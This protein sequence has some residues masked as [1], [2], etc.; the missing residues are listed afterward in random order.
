MSSSSRYWWVTVPLS[1]GLKFLAFGPLLSTHCQFTAPTLA[2]KVKS[3]VMTDGWPANLSWVSNPIKSPGSY[4]CYCHTIAGLLIWGTLCE[5]RMG[6]LFAVASDP[7]QCSHSQ[8]WVPLDSW[9]YFTV[10]HLRF[11]QPG[12]QVLV[13]ISPRNGMAQVYPQALFR[14]CCILRLTGLLWT[15]SNSPP[16]ELWPGS[17][18]AQ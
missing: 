9:P 6:F 10:S 15:Y 11:P 1:D 13:L 18:L 7:C 8:V 3:Y 12:G 17:A 14:F 5:E 2:V 16:H 4:F